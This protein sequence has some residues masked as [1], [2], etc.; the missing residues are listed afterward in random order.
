MPVAANFVCS[1]GTSV[2]RHGQVVRACVC[3]ELNLKN[4]ITFVGPLSANDLPRAHTVLRVTS[5]QVQALLPSDAIVCRSDL[6]PHYTNVFQP[7][8][9]VVRV[10]KNSFGLTIG[11]FSKRYPEISMLALAFDEG[12]CLV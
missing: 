6:D 2:D 11:Q 10:N 4:G 1:I 5:E 9:P 7:H 8:L 12:H 3:S